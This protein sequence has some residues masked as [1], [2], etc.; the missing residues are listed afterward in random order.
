MDPM[1]STG[2]LNEIAELTREFAELV[3]RSSVE[4]MGALL[5]TKT[6]G[7][8]GYRGDGCIDTDEQA[9]ACIAILSNWIRR[10]E[11]EL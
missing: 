1:P 10:T 4:V 5:S 8:L 3:G 7:R 9:R 2:Q 6:L 11:D